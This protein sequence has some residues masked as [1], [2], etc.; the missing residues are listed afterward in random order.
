VLLKFEF[1]QGLFTEALA[2]V[3]V[4]IPFMLSVIVIATFLRFSTKIKIYDID[5]FIS[6]GE[7]EFICRV[8]ILLYAIF[9]IFLHFKQ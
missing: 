3:E 7:Y 6:F 8:K 4:F 5:I 2:D 9:D 1:L